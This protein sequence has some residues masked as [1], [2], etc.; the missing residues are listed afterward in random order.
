MHIFVRLCLSSTV[1]IVAAVMAAEPLHTTRLVQ[2]ESRNARPITA[3]VISPKNVPET[4]VTTR[5]S[6]SAK[7]GLQPIGLNEAVDRIAAEH[8]L[9]A[10]LIHSI[11][12]V[13]SN[14]NRRAISSKGARGLMQLEPSTARRFGVADVFDPVDNVGGGVKYLTYLLNLYGGNYP[15]A[16]AAYNAGEAAVARYGGVPP[17]RETQTYLY[18]VWNHLQN[19]RKIASKKGVQPE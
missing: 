10:D 13:E 8:A 4:V 15:L 11:I 9:S 17:Y 2:P 16:L 14:Y 6:V 18:Q 7:S 12:Q 1:G 3:V 5:E 19:N